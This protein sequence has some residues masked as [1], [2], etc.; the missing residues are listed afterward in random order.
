MECSIPDEELTSKNPKEIVE[1]AKW[2]LYVDG[3]SNSKESESGL[4][5]ASPKCI[6]TKHALRFNFNISNNGMK[7][8]ALTIGL[9]MVK[10]LGVKRLKVFTDSQLVVE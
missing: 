6:V 7:Y 4:I 5:L 9:K 10:E 2:V 3:A 1:D 8:E